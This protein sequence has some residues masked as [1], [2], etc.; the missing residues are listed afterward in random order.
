MQS[1]YILGFECWKSGAYTCCMLEPHNTVVG[2][3]SALFR[4][5]NRIPRIPL[6]YRLVN[7]MLPLT[8]WFYPRSLAGNHN[9]ASGVGMRMEKGKLC[10]PCQAGVATLLAC[11]I[12]MNGVGTSREV[13]AGKLQNVDSTV[14]LS[15][16]S[17]HDDG[18]DQW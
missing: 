2:G 3:P 18:C 9:R 5:F 17:T 14:C 7:F 8:S 6:G 13:T 1:I 11:T 12:P 4:G 10:H 15:R 16:S